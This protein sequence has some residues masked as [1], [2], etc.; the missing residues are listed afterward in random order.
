MTKILPK[1]NLQD[2]AI[3]NILNRG[4]G[5]TDND[6]GSKFRKSNI[7][8][9]SLEKPMS[10]KNKGVANFLFELS[11]EDKRKCNYG[12]DMPDATDIDEMTRYIRDN[13][14]PNLWENS[15]MGWGWFYNP[16]TGTSED[17]YRIADFKGYNSLQKVSFT[18]SLDGGTVNQLENVFTIAGKFPFEKFSYFDNMYAGVLLAKKGS[19]LRGSFYVTGTRITEANGV[20]VK[21]DEEYSKALFGDSQNDGDVWYIAPF[22]SPEPNVQNIISSESNYLSNVTGAKTIPV[23]KITA[24]FSYIGSTA[25]DPM[26]GIKFAFNVKDVTDRR[27]VMECIATNEGSAH[28]MNLN[29]MNYT[30]EIESYN[31]DDGQYKMDTNGQP[32]STLFDTLTIPSGT[33]VIS[34]N[35]TIGYYPYDEGNNSFKTPYYITIHFS[36]YMTDEVTDKDAYFALGTARILYTDNGQWEQVE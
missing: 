31:L 2:H 27:I 19:S 16:P 21:L 1:T 35:M 26:N 20:D 32:S 11:E 33:S 9:Y 15:D 18:F 34:E 10:V 30:V 13:I 5:R 23:S 7:N 3:R 6:F 8:F 28:T 14:V 24:T 4:G 25:S 29:I 36:S 12:Y 22:L 17:P